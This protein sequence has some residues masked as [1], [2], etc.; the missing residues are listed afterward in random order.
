MELFYKWR[1]S[2]H[3]DIVYLE[4]IK[5]DIKIFKAFDEFLDRFSSGAYITV[6]TII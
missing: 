5:I 4:I 1:E 6:L 3:S 2:K